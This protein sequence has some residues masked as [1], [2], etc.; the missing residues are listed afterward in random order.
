MTLFLFVYFSYFVHTVLQ[1]HD[2]VHH[3]SPFPEVSSEGKTSLLFGVPR[4]D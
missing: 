1:S 2:T 3:L 4:R